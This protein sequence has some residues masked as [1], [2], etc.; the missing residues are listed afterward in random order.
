MLGGFE[1]RLHDST[2]FPLGLAPSLPPELSE[3]NR[4]KGS[5]CLEDFTFTVLFFFFFKME[6]TLLS[7]LEGGGV[8]LAHCN[9][10]L[11]G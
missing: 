5:S 10:C 2:A 11:P 3:L 9:L 7:R 6:H 4:G 1:T 8:I